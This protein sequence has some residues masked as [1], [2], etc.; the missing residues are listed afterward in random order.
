MLQERSNTILVRL[1]ARLGR[2]SQWSSDSPRALGA[3][4]AGLETAEK[5][6]TVVPRKA[7]EACRSGNPCMHMF[8]QLLTLQTK[9][10]KQHKSSYKHASPMGLLVPGG[11]WLPRRV[12][13]WPA[14]GQSSWSRQW[15]VG[16][17]W[18]AVQEPL[19]ESHGTH[20]GPLGPD[21]MKGNHAFPPVLWVD[22]DL[23]RSQHLVVGQPMGS[24]KLH[25]GVDLGV[26]WGCGSHH[27]LHFMDHFLWHSGHGEQG[28]PKLVNRNRA[29]WGQSLFI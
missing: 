23:G 13:G 9:K 10:Q 14:P 5:G 19:L 2:T 24:Q 22:Q 15:P 11:P 27:R 26:Y 8:M 6:D 20:L 7:Q 1:L 3:L 28:R 4:D 12:G 29:V 21:I 17:R 16:Y 25:D 18:S